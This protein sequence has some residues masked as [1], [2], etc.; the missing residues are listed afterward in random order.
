VTTRPGADGSTFLGLTS[1]LPRPRE[2]RATS[3]GSGST[4]YSRKAFKHW[5]TQA[6]GCSTREAVLIIEAVSGTRQG[7]AVIGGTWVS[8]YDGAQ[9]TDPGSFDI[10]HMVPLKEAW[11]SGASEWSPAKRQAFANDLGYIDSLIAVSAS[12]NRGKGDRDPARWMPPNP[13]VHCTYVAAW[14]AVKYRWGLA[15]DDDERQKVDSV[16]A[17]CPTTG[18]AMPEKA[19]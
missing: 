2:P 18:A 6:D 3:D 11:V 9:T 19:G 13:A 8:L 10:D 14:V 17:S 4:T 1:S 15:I 7:C 5:I 16:L 12:S